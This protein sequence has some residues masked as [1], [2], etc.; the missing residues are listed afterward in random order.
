MSPCT[1]RTGTVFNFSYG[2]DVSSSGAALGEIAVQR[3]GNCADV[4]AAAA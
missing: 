4:Q 1:T 2:N 3:W